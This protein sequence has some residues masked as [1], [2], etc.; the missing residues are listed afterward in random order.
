MKQWAKRILT[1]LGR[2]S[3]LRTLLI[4]KLKHLITS[5]PNPSA[6]KVTKLNK[7]FFEFLWK[8]STDKI[9]REIITQDFE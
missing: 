4:S 5:L 7:T 1:P 9:K 8:S 3:V 6:D 2:L